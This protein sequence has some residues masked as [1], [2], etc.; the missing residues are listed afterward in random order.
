MKKKDHCPSRIHY[1]GLLYFCIVFTCV[2]CLFQLV[3]VTP[4]VQSVTMVATRLQEI[5]GVNVTSQ[6]E[7]VTSVWY[8]AFPHTCYLHWI[9][10]IAFFTGK[11]Y[12]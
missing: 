7:Y 2:F 11:N 1:Y 5:V 4:L 12:L 8:V 3:S 6:E 10:E 9:I